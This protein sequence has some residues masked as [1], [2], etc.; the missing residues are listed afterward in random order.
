VLAVGLPAGNL[1]TAAHLAAGGL[2]AT[3]P[4]GRVAVPVALPGVAVTAAQ[5]VDVLTATPDGG[6]VRL[7]TSARV[8]SVDGDTVWVE[9]EREEAAA[10]AGAGA[11]GQL[12]VAVLPAGG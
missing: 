12:T 1:L 6:G 8:L 5:R 10:V 3:L 11:F 7:A 4:P 2:A 9:V